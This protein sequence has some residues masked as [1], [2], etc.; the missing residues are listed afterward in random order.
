MDPN[1][2]KWARSAFQDAAKRTKELFPFKTVFD[3]QIHFVGD[4]HIFTRNVNSAL[5][6]FG[7]RISKEG[8]RIPGGDLAIISHVRLAM[9]YQEH[10]SSNFG[11][12][13]MDR[14]AEVDADHPF[15]TENVGRDVLSSLGDVRQ[16]FA[17]GRFQVAPPIIPPLFLFLYGFSAFENGKMQGVCPITRDLR[18]VLGLAGDLRP[19]EYMAAYECCEALRQT[20]ALVYLEKEK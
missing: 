20:A 13:T 2:V 6:L 17:I 9:P 3:T 15:V 7:D 10:P 19:F 8:I 16:W 5:H 1:F 4:D 18:N 14:I 12:W 11:A